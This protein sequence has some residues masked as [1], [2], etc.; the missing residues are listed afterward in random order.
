MLVDLIRTLD[1]N[2][3]SSQQLLDILN[4]K[5]IEIVDNSSYTWAGIANLIGNDNTKQLRAILVNQDLL[6]V[7]DQLGGAGLSLRHPDVQLQLEDMYNSGFIPAK[8]LAEA[9]L[10]RISVLE[11]A[12]LTASIAEVEDA[13][14]ELKLQDLRSIKKDAAQDRL[15]AYFISLDS[16]DGSAGTEPVL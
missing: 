13:V 5:T 10:K 11:Q 8:V 7:V 12:N 1:Y 16:W 14:A 6:W 9:A 15:Y 4:D 2:N 3:L